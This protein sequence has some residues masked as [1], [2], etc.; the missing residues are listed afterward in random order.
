MGKI[1]LERSKRKII[2]SIFE[3]DTPDG[4]CYSIHF[5]DSEETVW[6]ENTSEVYAAIQKHMKETNKTTAL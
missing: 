1:I 5:T 2:D 6:C 4:K 3:H